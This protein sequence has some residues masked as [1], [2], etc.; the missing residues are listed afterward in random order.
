[1]NAPSN[2]LR[3]RPYLNLLAA[4]AVGL[5]FEMMVVR[6]L[7][8]E[9]RLFSYFKNIA[10]LAAFLGLGI[11]YGLARSRRDHLPSFLPILAILAAMTFAVGRLT[12][13]G[14]VIL[15]ESAEYIWRPAD[16]PP[17]VATPVFLLFLGMF[18][19]MVVLTFVPLGQLAGRMMIGLPPIPAYIANL[20]GSLAGVW[21][22][23]ALAGLS[24]PPWTWLVLGLPAAL[25]FLEGPVKRVLPQWLGAVGVVAGVLITQGGGQWSPYYRIDI[26][27]YR[28]G[29]APAPEPA[30]GY[31]LF[32]NQIGHMFALDLSPEFAAAHPEWGDTLNSYSLLY[33]LPYSVVEPGEVLVVGAGMG[34]DVAAG[35]RKGAGSVTA[36]EIDPVIAELGRRLHPEQPYLSPRVAVVLDDARSYLHRTSR[37]FDLIVFGVLDSQTLLSGMSSVRLDNFIYTTE[38]LLEARSHL[39]P[40]G[41]LALAFDVERW[42]I[43]RRLQDTLAEAFGEPPVRVSISGTAWRVYLSGRKGIEG[44]VAEYCRERGCQILVEEEGPLIPLATDDWPYLYLE[45]RTIPLPYLLGV[46]LVLVLGST[47]IRL[48]LGRAARVQ[49]RFFLLGAAFLLLEFKIITDMALLFGSTWIVNAAAVSA[50][51]IMVL[52]ANL[53]VSRLPGLRPSVLYVFMA[54]ALGINFLVPTGVLLGEALP[55]RVLGS[56]AL[57]GSPVFAAAAIYALALKS[58]LD[59]AGPLSASLLGSVAGGLLEYGSLVTGVRSLA[60]FAAVIYIAYG[61]IVSRDS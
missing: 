22:Y 23:A 35:L 51:L 32:V 42:W 24:S 53:A 5:Y 60:I 48:G 59:A 46:L 26:F 56:L 14:G 30:V 13:F 19:L 8:A 16:L 33:D 55:L 47:A 31:E 10:M 12:G 6:W 50:V 41:V 54:A 17:E 58:E 21:V 39:R 28:F 15:P 3:V 27:P 25:V 7:A 61:F 44:Q 43:A 11:G 29:T 4:S 1:M 2:K 9:I 36:V 40:G 57:L 49:G 52:A 18:F 34:N 38:A 45:R 20:L 37:R